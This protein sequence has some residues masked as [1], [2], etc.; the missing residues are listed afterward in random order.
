MVPTPKPYESKA[1][2]IDLDGTLAKPTYPSPEIGEPIQKMVDAVLEYHALGHELFIFTSRPESHRYDIEAWLRE[3]GL[4][5][6]FYDVVCGKPRASLYIDDRAISAD[7]ITQPER[8][9][10]RKACVGCGGC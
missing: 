7:A 2:A 9:V 8:C 3:H 10:S 6:V 1:I 4:D 5:R